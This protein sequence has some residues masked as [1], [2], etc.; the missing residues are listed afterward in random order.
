MS[1]AIVLVALI[2]IHAVVFFPAEIANATAGL[3][4]GF[5]VAL[6]MVLARL[7]RV[8]RDRLLPRRLV[9]RPLAVRL[10]GEKRVAAGEDV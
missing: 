8:G 2:L 1:G 3:V 5:W 9:G 6:P 4:F 10:A 7:G